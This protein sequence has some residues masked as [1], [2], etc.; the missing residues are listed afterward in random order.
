[1][2]YWI[3]EICNESS[4]RLVGGESERAGTVEVCQN[5]VWGPVCSDQWDTLDAAVVCRQLGY[6]FDGELTVVITDLHLRNFISA[7]K[8]Y[9]TNLALWKEI[10]HWVYA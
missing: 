6:P 2:S 4:V 8:Q 3:I 10:L 9:Q 1:M 5:G 7:R